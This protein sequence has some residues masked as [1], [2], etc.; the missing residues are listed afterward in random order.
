[1][2]KLAPL[3]LLAGCIAAPTPRCAHTDLYGICRLP[4]R[5]S[6][7]TPSSRARSA[8]SRSISEASSTRTTAPPTA[9]TASRVSRSADPGQTGT[10]NGQGS[11][12]GGTPGQQGNPPP[13]GSGTPPGG[14]SEPPAPAR[15]NPGNDKAVGGAGRTLAV[16][17]TARPA[18]GERSIE[19]GSRRR[20]VRSL[21][22][23]STR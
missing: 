14:S 4:E 5:L 21:P 6:P 2:W 10:P 20:R 22:A 1:M 17:A 3:L 18:A 19:W 9:A 23:R 8:P 13:G 15:G 7:G 16:R 12:P 11:P